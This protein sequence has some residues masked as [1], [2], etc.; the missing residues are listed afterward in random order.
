MG[1]RRALPLLPTAAL[2]LLAYGCGVAMTAT[3]PTEERGGASWSRHTVQLFVAAESGPRYDERGL[4]VAAADRVIVHYRNDTA[5]P[6]NI[7]FVYGTDA[8]DETLAAT[9]LA[10]GPDDA[11]TVTFVAPVHPGTYLYLCDAHPEEMRGALFVTEMQ[12]PDVYEARAR[13]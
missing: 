6:H 1:I 8:E 11:Q 10:A 3:P 9:K 12:L 5:E 2:A 13:P 7:R 4:V